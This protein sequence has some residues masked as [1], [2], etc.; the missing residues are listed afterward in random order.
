MNFLEIYTAMYKVHQQ[1]TY[2]KEVFTIFDLEDKD[3]RYK[4]LALVTSDKGVKHGECYGFRTLDYAQNYINDKID[5]AKARDERR[6]QNREADKQ[7]AKKFLDELKEGDILCSTW[8]YEAI[9][10]DFYKVVGKQ[11]SFV[12]LRE[13]AKDHDFENT[14]YGMCS[15]G[16]ASPTDSFANDEIIKRKA[17][18][19]YVRINS[20]ASATR[21]DG[22]PREEGC[23]H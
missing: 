13:L 10:Y 14:S 20:Y 18:N 8:G 6:A 5:R 7:G 22:K 11:G 17:C 12:L 16:V 23:W 21:W 19:G 3:P 4:Y 2:G 1:E 9:W 15:Y